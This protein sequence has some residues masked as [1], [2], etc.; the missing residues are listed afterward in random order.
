MDSA[1]KQELLLGEFRDIPEIG[2]IGMMSTYDL[3]CGL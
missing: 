2:E 1:N 3:G